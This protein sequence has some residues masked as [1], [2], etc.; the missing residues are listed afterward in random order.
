MTLTK[1]QAM[2]FLHIHLEKVIQILTRPTQILV[3]Q[4]KR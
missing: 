3:N 1:I 4:K 2:T